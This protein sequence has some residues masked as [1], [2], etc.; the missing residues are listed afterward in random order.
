MNTRINAAVLAAMSGLMILA[1][2]QAAGAS[3]GPDKAVFIMTNDA[4]SNEVVAFVRSEYG[5]L[6][7]PHRFKT[8][9]RGSG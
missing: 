5:T 6:A 9:G 1:V 4:E 8:G 3:F 7:F 2:G